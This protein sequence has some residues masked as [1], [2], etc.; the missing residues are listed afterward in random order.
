MDVDRERVEYLARRVEMLTQQLG[1]ALRELTQFGA[2]NDHLR[3][4]LVR[5]GSDLANH[6]AAHEGVVPM[7]AGI[8]QRIAALE[9]RFA[10]HL[11]GK[12]DDLRSWPTDPPARCECDR[13]KGGSEGQG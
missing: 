9:F 6:M 5:V 4:A 2:D 8:C 10:N 11:E 3:A 1:G 7:L 13:D 12:P